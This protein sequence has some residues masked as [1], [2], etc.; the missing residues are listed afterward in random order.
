LFA[1]FLL[2]QS[3][4]IYMFTQIYEIEFVA[5]IE[6]EELLEEKAKEKYQFFPS[7]MMQLPIT[8]FNRQYLSF[9]PGLYKEPILNPEIL[10]P[11]A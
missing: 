10:P 1:F 6:G 4:T 3:G 2:G 7:E 5:E 8:V 11:E 9:Q